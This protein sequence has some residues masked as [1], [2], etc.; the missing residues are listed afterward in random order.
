MIPAKISTMLSTT[1]RVTRRRRSASITESR[2]SASAPAPGR[3]PRPASSSAPK[4]RS[5]VKLAR[6]RL[7]LVAPV[8]E[9]VVGVE[10]RTIESF[11]NLLPW[12][13]V[14]FPQTDALAFVQDWGRT[15]QVVSGQVLGLD[16]DHVLT[17]EGGGDRFGEAP[18]GAEP[19]AAEQGQDDPATRQLLAQTLLPALPGADVVLV[20]KQGPGRPL[21]PDALADGCGD[22]G[23]LAAM[24]NED[25]GHP[26]P[27]IA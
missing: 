15:R 27:A 22:L 26:R 18:W 17:S 14:A 13:V 6:S 12:P 16:A 2:R 10:P 5:R 21:A 11:Q 7:R 19:V 4:P 24:A 25:V 8:P 3:P 1:S 20:V 9:P 23:I